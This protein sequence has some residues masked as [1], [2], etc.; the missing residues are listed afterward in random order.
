MQQLRNNFIIFSGFLIGVIC[1]ILFFSCISTE[2]SDLSNQHFYKYFTNI[3][4]NSGDTLWSIAN[5]YKDDHYRSTRAYI[6]EVKRMNNLTS[7]HIQA[8]THIIVP[9]YSN[10]FLTYN[11]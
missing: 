6:Q 4:V 10:E 5:T 7:D 3:E 1:I 8:G 11:D 2:A 9:Y